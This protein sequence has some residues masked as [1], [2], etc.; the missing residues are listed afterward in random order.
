MP[1]GGRTQPAAGP[2]VYL[3]VADI[4]DEHGQ[5]CDHLVV[6]R[7]VPAQRRLSALAKAGDA[8]TEDIRAIARLLAVFHA[9]AAR[10]EQITEQGGRDALA[11]RWEASFAQVQQVAGEVLPAA[12]FDEVCRRTRA[13]LAGRAALF[14]ARQAQGASSTAT[15]T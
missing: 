12:L 8:L 6:M 10:S 7:R 4:S 11:A 13:F 15:A 14:A 1:P 5:A 9:G 2:D 3:G